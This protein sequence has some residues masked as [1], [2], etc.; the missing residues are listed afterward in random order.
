MNDESKTE[1]KEPVYGNLGRC[2]DTL[3]QTIVVQIHA[4]AQNNNQNKQ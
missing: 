1:L 3:Y 2:T 4:P